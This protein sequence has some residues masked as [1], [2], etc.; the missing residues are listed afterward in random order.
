MIFAS[1]AL[2]TLL[3]LF[4]GILVHTGYKLKQKASFEE[5]LL[6]SASIL[7]W[8]TV[9]L[10]V[11]VGG[12]DPRLRLA[13]T[14]LIKQDYPSFIP[15]FVTEKSDE[16]AARLIFDLKASYPQIQ[17]VVAGPAINCGQKNHNLLTG[18]AAIEGIKPDCYAFCDST[19][20]AKNNFLQLLIQPIA[21]SETRIA[22]GYHE[23]TLKNGS[24]TAI[25]YAISVLFMR[26]LQAVAV[27]TQPWGG[28]MAI[29]RE[30]FI[31]A[32]IGKLWA[33]TVV[34]DCALVEHLNK[35]HIH[36]HLAAAATVK[37]I[38]EHYDASTW[39]AWMERQILF[40]RFCV[41]LQWW[42]LGVML[43][44]LLTPP[45]IAFED[46]ILTLSKEFSI[47]AFL[48]LGF[49][50]IYGL[51]IVNLKVFLAEVQPAWKFL[52]AFFLALGT[53]LKVYIGTFGATEIIWQNKIYKVGRGGIVLKKED[54]PT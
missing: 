40:P 46:F 13:L 54:L 32:E 52:A 48:P 41:P 27:F 34:D 25:A 28:A 39:Q 18:I 51:L 42:L 21:R 49:M 16:P 45:I 6:H 20:L 35:K 30:T 3:C 15:V 8:P 7:R 14:S 33:K 4:L 38:V 50:A 36:V 19:H 12:N 24:I 10:I 11:P 23:V 22:T 26:L 44:L 9:A 5:N 43:V 1:Y 31:K 29:T 2:L 53:F 37:T 17:H 47:R